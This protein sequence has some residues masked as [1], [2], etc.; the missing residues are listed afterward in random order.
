MSEILQWVIVGIA[1][2]LS[3]WYLY[4]RFARPKCCEGSSC[5]CDSCPLSPQERAECMEAGDRRMGDGPAD[6]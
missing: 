5:C 4:R 1:I 2:A 6:G 3:V